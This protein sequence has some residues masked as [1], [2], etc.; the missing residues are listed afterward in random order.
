MRRMVRILM[1]SIDVG[2]F[3]DEIRLLT[4]EKENHRTTFA[5]VFA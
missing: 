3:R 2:K 5:P 4:F 1:K